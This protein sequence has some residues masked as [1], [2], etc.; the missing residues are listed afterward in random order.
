MVL[1]H[2]FRG[3]YASKNIIVLPI[4]VILLLLENYHAVS[5][6]LRSSCASPEGR[7]FMVKSYLDNLSSAPT[8][9][10][11]EASATT[12]TES[13]KV[14]SELL[15]LKSSLSKLTTKMSSK[16]ASSRQLTAEEELKARK[17]ESSISM[18]SGI[19]SALLSRLEDLSA[20][21]KSSG[22]KATISPAA[23]SSS[24]PRRST[25][26][27]EQLATSLGTGSSV[28]TMEANIDTRLYTSSSISPVSSGT[29]PSSGSNVK[30]TPETLNGSVSTVSYRDNVS[31]K[32]TSSGSVEGSIPR[33]VAS[34]EKQP[35]SPRS[36]T[37]FMGSYLDSLS[38]K[39]SSTNL[40][41]GGI[42]G[43]NAEIIQKPTTVGSSISAKPLDIDKLSSIAALGGR[44]A[45]TA[46]SPV[47]KSSPKILESR[48]AVVSDNL[49]ADLSVDSA[50]SIILKSLEAGEFDVE[51][52][53]K[54]G[55]Y[56][57]TLGI[58][59]GS[60]TFVRDSSFDKISSKATVAST[61]PVGEPT[62]SAS[63][64]QRTTEIKPLT[65]ST[66]TKVASQVKPKDPSKTQSS[67]RKKA[68]SS[69]T[70]KSP[71]YSAVLADDDGMAETK[72]VLAVPTEDATMEVLKGAIPEKSKELLNKSDDG[73]IPANLKRAM[74][75]GYS[76]LGLGIVS[77]VT[78]N[79]VTNGNP[80]D[81]ASFVQGFRTK[82]ESVVNINSEDLEAESTDEST[83]DTISEDSEVEFTGESAVDTISED[84]TVEPTGE[85]S[86]DAK[87]EDLSVEPVGESAIGTVVE[88]TGESV[89][90][91]ESEEFLVDATGESAIGIEAEAMEESEIGIEA[92]S[93]GKSRFDTKSEET[94]VEAAGVSAIDAESEG[95]EVEFTGESGIPT[96]VSAID[97]KSE[98]SEGET[99]GL[100]AADSEAQDSGVESEGEL[101]VDA[102]AEVSETVS[103]GEP[104]LDTKSE[105]SG[106]E[107]TGESAVDTISE[108]LSV[109]SLGESAVDTKS[110][111][112]SLE[113]TREPTIDT[114]S[115]ASEAESTGEAA[116][117]TT[118]EDSGAEPMSEP[119]VDTKFEDSGARTTEESSLDTP[120][121]D[122][123]PELT[124][125][126]EIDGFARDESSNVEST[127]DSKID[128][129]AEPLGK[130][131]T[132]LSPISTSPESSTI[133][134]P[135]EPM[136]EPNP[137]ELEAETTVRSLI[138]TNPKDLVAEVRVETAVSR[139]LKA[140]GSGEVTADTAAK[141]E[142]A[143]DIFLES[144]RTKDDMV[145]NMFSGKRP[146]VDSAISTFLKGM[147]SGDVTVETATMVESAIE[148]FLLGYGAG[149]VKQ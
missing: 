118:A 144:F 45:V 111:D 143:I 64:D 130:E 5:A 137:M 145:I 78:L 15:D 146:T 47:F 149:E 102:E 41:D 57:K 76:I 38:S 22:S 56:L 30:E 134:I 66:E 3:S 79:Y 68:P 1:L 4:L 2:L 101:A 44:A 128:I 96:G 11:P 131:A 55:T 28:S 37:S 51:T 99:T 48:A 74:I 105:D 75:A 17:L 53:T 50:I 135:A 80:P 58:G 132:E 54:I 125:E 61:L 109:E 29:S 107:Y 122:I 148:K 52:A 40:I 92:E 82:L 49:E 21:K 14:V 70:G 18:I 10:Y 103:T 33:N 106:V 73:S 36:S 98:D 91:T 77:G 27:S 60:T 43:N 104:V 97:A 112:F 26:N 63:P 126:S 127:E 121:N 87:S 46:D 65:T 62:T 117:D 85:S 88:P 42:R 147:A 110:E 116:S 9:S 142:S 100:P 72:Q 34:S 113:N 16:K 114:K 67:Y 123:A 133:G 24:V 136:I 31:N 95:S 120:S 71:F 108:D 13:D 69:L 90:D 94:G 35:A 23:D 39:S 12:L 89:I 6:F 83:V 20:S 8:K 93:M 84:S 138:S 139:F 7:I 140:L 115:E 19:T 141:V 81:L 59:E 119:A 25:S 32:P 86:T 129:Y 124:F